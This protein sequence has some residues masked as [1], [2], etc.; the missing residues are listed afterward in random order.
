MKGIVIDKGEAHYTY[1]GSIFGSI[2]NKQKDYN[3]L[4]TG[5]ECYPQNEKYAE[6][7]SKEWCWITGAE[8]TEMIEDENFQWIWGVF[9]AFPKDVTEDVVLKYRLS[10]ADGNDR[11]FENPISM[12]HLLSVMEIIECHVPEVNN[13]N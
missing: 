3:W 13:E 4:I 10:K 6:K 9:S 5:H 8:L 1:L 11:I 2:E 7:L 12:Q